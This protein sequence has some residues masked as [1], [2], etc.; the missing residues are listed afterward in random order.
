MICNIVSMQVERGMHVVRA[1]GG[2][3]VLARKWQLLWD[4]KF[5]KLSNSEDEAN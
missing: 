3:A 1:T 2:L 5:K 4:S